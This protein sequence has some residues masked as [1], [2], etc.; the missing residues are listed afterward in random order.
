MKSKSCLIFNEDQ[1]EKPQDRVDTG[2]AKSK[3]W[4]GKIYLKGG[5]EDPDKEWDM[6][7]AGIPSSEMPMPCSRCGKFHLRT[8]ACDKSPGS[9]PAPDKLNICDMCGQIIPNN[10]CLC[11]SCGQSM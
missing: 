1:I 9:E 4:G 2:A 7:A 6:A 5:P 11:P 10:E 8:D 3:C